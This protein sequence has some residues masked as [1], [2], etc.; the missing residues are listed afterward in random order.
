MFAWAQHLCNILLVEHCSCLLVASLNLESSIFWIESRLIGWSCHF[1]NI[2][3]VSSHLSTHDGTLCSS[4]CL[5]DS[6]TLVSAISLA[7]V[8]LLWAIR[9]V[10]RKELLRHDSATDIV[11]MDRRLQTGLLVQAKRELG[12]TRAP[13]SMMFTDQDA[14]GSGH[15]SWVVLG[16]GRHIWTSEV[17]WGSWTS[18]CCHCW[19][20]VDC[21]LSDLNLW[22]FSSTLRH[23]IWVCSSGCGPC[24][25]NVLLCD[26]SNASPSCLQS[27]PLV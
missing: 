6:T 26:A 27:V 16:R 7:R 12:L 24:Q 18:S 15:S 17:G 23:P 22:K 5:C 3:I 10:L 13:Y 21:T 19:L 9:R 2:S 25:P 1:W 11:Y 4:S 20:M 14:L 8:S